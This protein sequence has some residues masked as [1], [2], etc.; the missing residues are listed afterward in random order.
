M[1]IHNFKFVKRSKSKPPYLVG[2]QPLDGY[3]AYHQP[4]KNPLLFT[5][6]DPV[7]ELY[8]TFEYNGTSTRF[9]DI[10]KDLMNTVK[11]VIRQPIKY[12]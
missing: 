8:H 1:Y 11:N 12:R 2:Y 4:K 6:Y 5:I 10:V 9:G 7:K 3:D